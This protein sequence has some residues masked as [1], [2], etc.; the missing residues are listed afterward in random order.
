MKEFNKAVVYTIYHHQK[1]TDSTSASMT[2]TNIQA[3][4]AYSVRLN[5]EKE[6]DHLFLIG[7]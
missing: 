1:N 6:E 4:Q 2:N 7:S 5:I 3:A